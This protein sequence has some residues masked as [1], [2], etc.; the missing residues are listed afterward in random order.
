MLKA[1]ITPK[2]YQ[3]QINTL[4]K[5]NTGRRLKNID[6]P[7]LVLHGKEDILLPPENAEIIADK[8]PDAKLK[9]FD[10]CGH[11]LF[12]HK[13]EHLSEVVMDFLNNSSG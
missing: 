10:G 13:P 8:I 3:R 11:A 2:A 6:A 1:P 12:S 7:T 4:L 5:F 9:L